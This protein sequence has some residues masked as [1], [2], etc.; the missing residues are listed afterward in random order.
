[1]IVQKYGGV[2]VET[3]EKIKATANR[4]QCDLKTFGKMVVVVSAM[5]STT[6]NL[7]S[8]ARSI[9]DRPNL[10]E[11]DMLLT[12]GERI[13]A[14]LMTMALLDLGVKATSL[15]GSQAGI[16]TT[17]N[18]SNAFIKDIRP[19]RIFDL[20]KIY[21]VIVIA[22]F[23][24]VSETTKNITTLGRGGSDT[25]A[26]ALAAKLGAKACYIL[27]EVSSIL[28]A[29]PKMTSNAKPLT[30][31]T[32]KQASQLTFWGAKVLH[33]R[34]T[35]IAERFKIPIYVGPANNQMSTGTW[36]QEENPN[37]FETP[38]FY[39]VTSHSRVL[40]LS[41]CNSLN[42]SESL[43]KLHAEFKTHQII[44][45][46]ILFA[47]FRG[48]VVSEFFITG[49]NEA[50][51]LIIKTFGNS[52]N[53]KLLDSS[54]SSV[55]L[56]AQPSLSPDLQDQVMKLIQDLDTQVHYL[57]VTSEGLSLIVPESKSKSLVSH[58]HQYLIVAPSTV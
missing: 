43:V 34:S 55:T 47:Q 39:A 17:E 44:D 11:L 42:V 16:I 52:D 32:F 40:R 51:D 22:G 35:K 9:S 30:Q 49:P 13:S 27:K 2:T 37:M 45:P 3:P 6:N 50:L 4:I 8:L 28:S 5:G 20:L 12:T 54:L 24:G 53:W 33:H 58:F 7:I 46:Q 26:I 1:M 15:T 10:R 48:G 41:D 56:H 25:T 23:Q 18:H 14:S 29:D 38:K 57:I 19:Q 21:D 36:I 31:I